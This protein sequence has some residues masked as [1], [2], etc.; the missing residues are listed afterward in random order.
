MWKKNHPIF[1]SVVK[2]AFR[3]TP[4]CHC[5][6]AL[7]SIVIWLFGTNE[8]KQVNEK[9]PWVAMLSVKMRKLASVITEHPKQIHELFIIVENN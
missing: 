3:I 8:N 7:F 1:I 9:P 4:L 5:C 2:S 6:V